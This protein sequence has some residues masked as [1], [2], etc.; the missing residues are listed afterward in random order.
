MKPTQLL[1][2]ISL[3]LGMPVYAADGQVPRLAAIDPANPYNSPIKRANPNS[4]Q[5]TIPA[6]PPVRGPSTAPV[7]R[8]ATLDNRGVGNGD[9]LRRAPERPNLEPTR[10]PRDSLRTP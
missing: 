1:M 3:L 7:E 2:V 9:N 4:R 10:P 5:G 8:P 6:T